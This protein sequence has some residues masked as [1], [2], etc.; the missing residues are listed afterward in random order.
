MNQLDS[1]LKQATENKW[2]YPKKFEF[3]KNAGVISHSVYF[4]DT[5]DS[6]YKG[7]FG[8]WNEPTPAN[9]VACTLSDIFSADSIKSAMK[10]HGQGKRTYVQFLMDIAAAGVSHY[11]VDMHSQL[12]LILMNKKINF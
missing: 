7:S 10:E 3:F 1:I 8:H 11:I 12:L 6:V 2:S 4:I 9:Y 5:F